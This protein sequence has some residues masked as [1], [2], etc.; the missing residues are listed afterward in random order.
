MNPA[1]SVPPNVNVA[2]CPSVMGPLGAVAVA[3]I[4]GC[5]SVTATDPWLPGFPTALPVIV[6]VCPADVIA[7]GALYTVLVDGPKVD[8]LPA[9][10]KLQFTFWLAVT[11][12][13]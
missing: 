5:S 13:C 3:V 9:P 4:E 8:R 2:A 10:A 1:E 12:D 7:F 6:A 11:V